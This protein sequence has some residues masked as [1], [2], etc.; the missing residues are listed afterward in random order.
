MFA[1]SSSKRASRWQLHVALW[2]GHKLN[3]DEG[4]SPLQGLVSYLW[5][6][7]DDTE[8]LKAI[9]FLGITW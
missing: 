6:R 9:S 5:G 1:N 2:K 8:K 7:A 3:S 4:P